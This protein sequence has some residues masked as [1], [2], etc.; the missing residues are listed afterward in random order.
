MTTKRGQQ[1]TD[2]SITDPE[3][4]KKLDN[5][6]LPSNPCLVPVSFSMPHRP[7]N[8]EGDDLYRKL[9]ASVIELSNTDLILVAMKRISWTIEQGQNY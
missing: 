8:W 6:Y 5:N 7:L 3:F 1:L 4:V 2:A 9:I